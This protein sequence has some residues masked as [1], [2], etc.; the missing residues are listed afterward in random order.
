MND[1]W[2]TVA[3]DAWKTLRNTVG[4]FFK[5]NGGQSAGAFA[6]DAFFALFP[7]MILSV[8]IASFVLEPKSAEKVVV[9]YIE[10][11]VSLSRDV[12]RQIFET[13]A[14]VI[15]AR[16]QAGV[17]AFL[18]LVWVAGQTFTT[19]IQAVNNAWGT[20]VV[21]WWRL[22]LKSLL[23]LGMTVS[24][25]LLGITLPMYLR[26][27]EELIRPVV[28]LH[29][30]MENAGSV[31]IPYAFLLCGLGVFYKMAPRRTTRWSEIWFGALFA[32]GL[33][34]AG[35]RLFVLY[36]TDYATLNAVYGAFGGIMAL[37]LWIYISGCCVILG[38]CLS[39]SQVHSRALERR[40]DSR[41]D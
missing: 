25:L 23:L 36:L 17:V 5:I 38:A 37:L 10:R 34:A 21:S 9:S 19:L 18:L 3:H 40:R 7:L 14:G 4:L 12:E 6:F 2:K 27:V 28:D 22:P 29:S 33:L 16:E 35:E 15:E 39:A 30:W 13:I 20:P 26:I 8:S 11:T 1:R 32:T 24:V 41:A 31:L